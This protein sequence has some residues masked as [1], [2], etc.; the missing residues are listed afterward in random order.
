[1]TS[2]T[3]FGLDRSEQMHLVQLLETLTE[4][5]VG[6]N[7][8]PVT[9]D[10]A[11]TR[12][13]HAS[14]AEALASKRRTG[15]AAPQ[16]S[17]KHCAWA[18]HSEAQGNLLDSC[19]AG[20]SLSW[21]TLRAL[22]V[23]LWLK[24]HKDLQKRIEQLAKSQFLKKRDPYDCALMYVALNRK[25]VLLGL[26]KTVRDQKLVSFLAR[27]FTETENQTAAQKN[28][29]VLMGKHRYELA[30]AFFLLG[31]SLEDA[32][33]VCHRNMKDPQLAVVIC[34]LFGGEDCQEKTNLLEA[35]VKEAR[36][37]LDIWQ[38]SLL[39]WLLGRKE[40]SIDVLVG[41]N[42]PVDPEVIQLLHSLARKPDTPRLSPKTVQQLVWRAAIAY[43]NLGLPAEALEVL[44]SDLSQLH[45]QTQISAAEGLNE[46]GFQPNGNDM[47][48]HEIDGLRQHTV[49]GGSC[50]S[51]ETSEKRSAPFVSKE[52]L[53]DALIGL[54]S[55][56]TQ[57]CILEHLKGRRDSDVDKAC[58]VFNEHFNVKVDIAD[59]ILARSFLLNSACNHDESPRDSGESDRDEAMNTGPSQCEQV[60]SKFSKRAAVSVDEYRPG[61]APLGAPEE[62]F[63]VSTCTER[64]TEVLLFSKDALDAL[65]S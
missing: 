41:E 65:L 29:Y 31:N 49:G 24:S 53:E 30:A 28:A 3:V 57:I 7:G 60:G 45:K 47:K 38:E 35:L 11:G 32:I 59:K 17:S 54:K 33:S 43:R 16:L 1:M 42:S 46:N 15:L 10:Y 5:D 14:R 8:V 18:L 61:R 13:R 22:K 64:R 36:E 58:D 12:C 56:W 27:D 52:I 20:E 50:V 44:H 48:G 55:Q 2:R 21:E 37:S 4:A 23:G 6:K 63:L 39:E 9:L 62:I 34:R 40:S 26:F 51:V 19:L 25:A